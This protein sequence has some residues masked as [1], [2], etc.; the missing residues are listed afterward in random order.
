MTKTVE[1]KAPYDSQI[2]KEEFDANEEV[3]CRLHPFGPSEGS[4]IEIQ[5]VDATLEVVFGPMDFN[6]EPEFTYPWNQP[7][8]LVKT[9]IYAFALA[10][11]AEH[12]ES[13]LNV[14]VPEV[15]CVLLTDSQTDARGVARAFADFSDYSGKQRRLLA[16]LQRDGDA[17]CMS[18]D[19]IRLRDLDLV[20]TY[21]AALDAIADQVEGL[22]YYET[23]DPGYGYGDLHLGDVA[24]EKGEI[25]E[26]MDHYKRGLE[27]KISENTR[28][29]VHRKLGELSEE[30]GEIDDAISHYESALEWNPK[31]GVKKK[32]AALLASRDQ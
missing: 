22:T 1:I 10:K 12:A 9:H 5:Q 29:S 21:A 16:T 25:A 4:V 23:P 17:Y 14:E 26:A 20:Y 6:F 13:I 8:E 28:A 24:L 11:A 7:P 15:S 2:L 19:H 31:V 18:I 32:L 3:V 27:R 30:M